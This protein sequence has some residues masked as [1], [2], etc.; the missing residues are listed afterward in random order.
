MTCSAATSR[1]TTELSHRISCT[2]SWN[3]HYTKMI[4]DQDA[5]R[6]SWPMTQSSW[7]TFSPIFPLRCNTPSPNYSKSHCCNR[8]NHAAA[9]LIVC[10]APQTFDKWTLRTCHAPLHHPP[11]VSIIN[12]IKLDRWPKIQ[13]VT[14]S[15]SLLGQLYGPEYTLQNALQSQKLTF[16]QMVWR[17]WAICLI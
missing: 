14:L 17:H 13:N 11:N 8:S 3:H 4:R 2:R 12:S 5:C 6:V 16:F 9:K 1:S 10:V 7:P 15:H